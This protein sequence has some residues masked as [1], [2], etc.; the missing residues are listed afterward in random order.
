M[1]RKACTESVPS[2]NKRKC[3]DKQPSCI[4]EVVCMP[5]VIPREHYKEKLQD[6]ILILSKSDSQDFIL[7]MVTRRLFSWMVVQSIF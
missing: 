7:L 4:V 3:I 6:T 2:N 5:N 1:K